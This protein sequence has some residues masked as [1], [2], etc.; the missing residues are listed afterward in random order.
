MIPQTQHNVDLSCR[1]RIVNGPKA[2]T[3]TNFLTRVGAN[4]LYQDDFFHFKCVND[5]YGHDRGDG[6]LREVVRTTEPLLRK[7]DHLGHWGGEDFILVAPETNLRRSGW[8]AERLRSSIADQ[9][10]NSTFG[11]TAS[12]G[13]AEYETDEG[14]EAL[15][16]RAD[17]ALYK[18]K[19]L[20]RDRVELAF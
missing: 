11:V 17:E 7:T 2:W 10:F 14:L 18:A 19:T 12:F 20:G 13:L 3:R 16:K 5:T 4:I 1:L 15:I 8:L 9:E 6:V